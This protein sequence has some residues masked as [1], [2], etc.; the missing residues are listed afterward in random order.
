MTTTHRPIKDDK[1]PKPWI[2]ALELPI[3]QCQYGLNLRGALDP[4]AGGVGRM[5]VGGRIDEALF[6]SAADGSLAASQ[7]GGATLLRQS[8]SHR[9]NWFG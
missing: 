8:A 1:S 4:V 7:V 3:A 2:L 6:D 5:G 9:R